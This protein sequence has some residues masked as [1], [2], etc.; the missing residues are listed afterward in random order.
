MEV[1]EY[2]YRKEGGGGSEGMEVKEVKVYMYRKEGN[3]KKGRRWMK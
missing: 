1:K 3:K 2:M